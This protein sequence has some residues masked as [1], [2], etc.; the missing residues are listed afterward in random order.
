MK[1]PPSQAVSTAQP[2]CRLRHI[3]TTAEPQAQALEITHACRLCRR[4]A[5]AGGVEVLQTIWGV[6]YRLADPI[7]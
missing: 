4:L 1:S 7:E 2:T 5:D 3:P 6:G